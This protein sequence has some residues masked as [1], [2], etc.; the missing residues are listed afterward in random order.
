MILGMR[1]QANDVAGAVADAG[2]VVDRAVGIGRVRP[3]SSDGIIARGA[4][5]IGQIPEGD[6]AVLE[7][8]SR[9]VIA[10]RYPTFAVRDRTADRRATHRTE[11]ARPTRSF[12]LQGDPATLETT[13]G[14]FRERHRAGFVHGTRQQ[15]GLHQDLETVADAEHRSRCLGGSRELVGEP[16]AQLERQTTTGTECI[17]VAE[18]SGQED[19]GVVGDPHCAA[20]QLVDVSNGG[21]SACEFD[22]LGSLQVAIGAGRMR[23][24][25]RDAHGVAPLVGSGEPCVDADIASASGILMGVSL[26]SSPSAGS[27]RWKTMSSPA[28]TSPMRRP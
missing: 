14:V 16:G 24:Q 18:A 25:D 7:A 6:E 1:H 27:S 11:P 19:C 26:E 28:V 10:D 12:H 9:G 17:A 13:L 5:T 23:D 20:A 4:G 21:G 22:R 2:D 15:P 3:A 8:S